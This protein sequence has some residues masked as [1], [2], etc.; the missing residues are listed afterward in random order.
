MLLKIAIGLVTSKVIAIFVGPAGMALLGNLRNFMSSL[1]TIATLGFQNGIVKYVAENNGNQS[2]LKKVVSTVLIS[3]AIVA[4]LLSGILFFMADFWNTYL[5]GSGSIYAFI[6]KALAAAFPW[7]AA[8]IA[9]VAIINGLSRFKDVI[10]ITIIGNITGLIVSLI[11]IGYYRTSGALLSIIITPSL[12]FFIALYFV[13][14]EIRLKEHIAL[15]SFSFTVIKKMGAYS[16]MAFVSAVL[17]PLVVLSIR[18]NVMDTVGM[19]QAGFWEAISRISVYYLMFITTIMTVYFLPKLVLAKDNNETKTVFRTYYTTLMPVY[20]LGLLLLFV[21][22]DFVIGLLFTKDFLPVRNLFLWQL[23]GDML[24]GFSMI[25]GYNLV[26]KKHTV[27]FVITELVSMGI[28]Y[29]SSLYLVSVFG[30]EGVVMAHC[31]TYTVYLL[32]LVVYFRK[33]LLS[34]QLLA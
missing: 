28:M 9:M 29:L 33:V 26:A 5:F 10:Y 8:S 14:R 18:N 25:L 19:T 17:S 12:V 21:C 11:L 27:V 16:L 22:R 31:I 20:I 6:F 15:Q 3:I 1:E 34:K 30:V 13:N 32:V 4:L 24:K 23:L 7:Y 2:E